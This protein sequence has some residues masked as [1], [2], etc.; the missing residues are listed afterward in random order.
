MRLKSTVER[1]IMST[2]SLKASA[3]L[4]AI[5]LQPTGRR[6]SKSPVLTAIRALRIC[7]ASKAASS[8]PLRRAGAGPFSRGDDWEGLFLEARVAGLTAAKALIEEEEGTGEA[9]C[10]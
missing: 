4:P 8:P 6:T 7:S 3:T 9:L 10:R 1:D 5:P 2:T